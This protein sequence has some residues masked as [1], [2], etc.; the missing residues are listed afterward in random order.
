MPYGVGYKSGKNQGTSA[1]EEANASKGSS[2]S[3]NVTSAKKSG[4]NDMLGYNGASLAEQHIGFGSGGI[5]SA[6][7]P[8]K[9]VGHSQGSS[10]KEVSGE[11][12]KQQNAYNVTKEQ[13][14][15][16]QLED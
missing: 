2:E 14:R 9:Q 11:I 6:A 1:N 8:S 5:S 12:S 15:K 7:Q 10:S 3:K 4:T 16:T 13:P